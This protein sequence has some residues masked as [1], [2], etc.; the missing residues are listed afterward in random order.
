MLSGMTSAGGP[1]PP[2][3]NAPVLVVVQ[4]AKFISSRAEY[5]V[6]A[7]DGS[8]YASVHQQFG[9]G[10]GIFG[11]LATITYEVVGADGRVLMRMVKPS[12]IGRA[13]FDVAWGGGQPLGAISQENLL[14]APQFSLDAVD[15]TSARL[16]GGSLMSWE[17]RLEDAAG[18]D[19]GSV[20]K[21]FAGLAELFSS[22]DKFV[23]QLSAQLTG[24]LRALAIVATV[25]LDEVRTAKRRR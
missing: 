10:A 21:Q 11:Q 9:S 1:V 8:P 24:D 13:R 17:W 18:Q 22:A 16:T 5:D 12:N 4:R 23:V 3:L 15:G 6:Y 20:S 2:L 14:F 7:P 19:I 25:C